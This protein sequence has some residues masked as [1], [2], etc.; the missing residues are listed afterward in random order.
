MSLLKSSCERRFRQEEHTAHEQR[1]CV[2]PAAPA[3]VY[4]PLTELLRSG[5]RRLIEA[6]VSA[7]FEE[8]LSAFVQEKLPRRTAAGGSQRSPSGAQ[9]SHRASGR[10][11]CGCPRHAA[12]RVRRNRSLFGGAAVRSALREP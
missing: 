9:D 10:W 1:Y 3:R 4:D 12:A 2:S 7:E 8:Y 5:A 6:A 11:T